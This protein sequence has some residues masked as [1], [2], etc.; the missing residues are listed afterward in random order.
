M[1]WYSLDDFAPQRALNRFFSFQID[2]D[3][4]SPNPPVFASQD[5]RILASKVAFDG[6]A[7]PIVSDHYGLEVEFDF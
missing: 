5:I 2:T 3:I 6:G 4:V 7:A 1:F